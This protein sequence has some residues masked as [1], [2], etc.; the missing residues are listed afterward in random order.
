MILLNNKTDQWFIVIAGIRCLDGSVTDQ[1][2]AIALTHAVDHIDIYSSS[3]GPKDDGESAPS[4]ILPH[5]TWQ[6]FEQES[7]W[8]DRRHSLQKLFS[9]GWQWAEEGAESSTFGRLVTEVSEWDSSTTSH[10][11]VAFSGQN[12]DNCNCDGYVS[13]IYTLSIG[14]VTQHGEFPWYGE[15]CASTLAVAF[16]SGSLSE[17]K[18]FTTTLHGQC[19]FNHT[20]TSAAAPIAAG[21]IA[22][23]LESNPNLTWRDVKHLIVWT[24]SVNQLMGNRGWR[25]NAVGLLYNSRFGFGLIDASALILHGARWQSVGPLVTCNKTSE[26]RWVLMVQLQEC[27]FNSLSPLPLYVWMVSPVQ[28]TVYLSP[29]RQLN[30]LVN[31]RLSRER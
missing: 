31:W 27:L 15:R 28:S 26:L 12:H 13:S 8:M 5:V 20:G 11:V 24:S 29:T 25:K 4:V 10:W 9:S 2:E 3:W 18:V 30:P 19:A 22:L 23:L 7:L 6:S 1:T 21:V 17:S 14:A 16:S